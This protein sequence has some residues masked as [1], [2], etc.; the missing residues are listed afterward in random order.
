MSTQIMYNGILTV[1][2]APPHV[3]FDPNRPTESIAK[4]LDFLAHKYLHK[5]IST[6][7][8]VKPAVTH[9][10]DLMELVRDHEFLQQLSE[11]EFNDKMTDIFNLEVIH[12]ILLLLFVKLKV[13]IVDTQEANR[14]KIIS[15]IVIISI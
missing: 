8:H 2:E 6:I 4:S 3:L 1:L 10:Q 5:K 9:I 13:H 7:D 12:N 11:P 15:F 14:M